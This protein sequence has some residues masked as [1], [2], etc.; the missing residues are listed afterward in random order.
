MN[1]EKHIIQ[2]CCGK[3]SVI[4]KTDQP[5]NKNHIS[6]L[7]KLGFNENAHFSKAGILYVD[8]L[9]FIMTGPL[10]AN[11]LQVKCKSANC[12]QKISGLEALLLQI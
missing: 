3:A 9:D 12:E 5:L 10:G 2:S 1:V 11:R 4:F 6:N 7:V 8:N